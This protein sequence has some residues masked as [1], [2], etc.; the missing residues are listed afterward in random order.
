MAHLKTKY[1]SQEAGSDS[2]NAVK[3]AID[4]AEAEAAVR[5]LI[6]WAG[7]N[8]DREGLLDTPS[9]VL[10]VYNELFVGYNEDPAEVLAKT[11]EESDEYNEVVLLKNIPVESHCEHHMVPIIGVAHVGY[12]PSSRVVGISKLARVV[13]IFCRRLQIQERLTSEIARTIFEV[14]RPEGVGVRIESSHQCMT[15]RGVCMPGV[16]MVTTKFYGCYD[17]NLEAKRDLVNMMES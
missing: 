1:T 10:K 8:P 15:T 12:L 11:F 6:R 17:K 14:L 4:E 16:S 7:D 13:N 2:S 9:R 3:S 5:T